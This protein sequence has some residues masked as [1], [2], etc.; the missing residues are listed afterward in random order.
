MA[1]EDTDWSYSS[2]VPT[3]SSGLEPGGHYI[4]EGTT[5]VSNQQL[6]SRLPEAGR[7]SGERMQ[8]NSGLSHRQHDPN[9]FKDRM[10]SYQDSGFSEED[11]D[12]QVTTCLMK[13]PSGSIYIQPTNQKINN[14]TLDTRLDSHYSQPGSG[15]IDCLRKIALTATGA[16]LN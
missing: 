13:T 12:H 5:L 8:L 3:L 2:P 10:M 9:S 11:G 7:I 15:Q 14:M 16:Q 1:E 4:H 6:R